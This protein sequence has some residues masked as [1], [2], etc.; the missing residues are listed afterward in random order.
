MSERSSNRRI[1]L[2]LCLFALVFA[3]T[4][5]RAVWLQGVQAST[6]ERIAARQH[7][8]TTEIPAGR[9][10]IYDRTGEPLAIGEQATTVYADP[11]LVKNPR[12]VALAAAKALGL[13]AEA[14]YPLLADQT[15]HFVYVKRKADPAKA[16]ELERQH[17]AGRRL[18][19]RGAALLPAAGRCG[20]RA[21]LRRCRQRRPRRP[22][23]IARQA[24]DRQAGQPD[25]HHR[26]G[27]PRH[28]RRRDGSRSRPAT[29]S[30]SRSTTASR[31]NAESV[32]RETV[33][34]WGAKAGN[35]I[36]LDPRTGAV[37]AMA[38]AP[39]YD[40]NRFASASADR[41]RNRSVTDVYEPGS[42]FKVVTV[43]AA[44]SEKIVT[45]KTPV[46]ACRARSGSPTGSSTSTSRARPSG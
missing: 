14:L 12:R 35:A 45:P 13:D 43:A 39:G 30:S 33:K 42:T 26:S 32:L 25:D 41:R 36:V 4:L 15:R 38:V 40:A 5:G 21:R 1:R 23:A 18:L 24:A 27:R 19:P 9:G 11:R 3:G 20:A 37:L 6:L 17:L 29:T 31:R 22:R 16:A 8:Q 44:L 46:H 28:R 7:E 10:T 2:L 34:R